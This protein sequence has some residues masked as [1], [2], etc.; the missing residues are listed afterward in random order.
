[1]GK[2]RTP[3]RGSD[4]YTLIEL[5]ITVAIIG[6]L[7]A[8]A[9][10]V[11]S[12]YMNKSRAQEAIQFLGTIKLRQESYRSEFGEYCDVNNINPGTFASPVTGTDAVNWGSPGGGWQQLG[13][14]PDGPVRFSFETRAGP[15]GGSLPSTNSWVNTVGSGW[16]NWGIDTADFWYVAEA[17]GDLNSD[18]TLVVFGTAAGMK[19]IWCSQDKGWD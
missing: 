18:G 19:N 17:A 5:M 11:F 4:A 15:P 14:H 16:G 13:A 6:I 8:I 9:I 10:P 3:G 1:M 7:S 12:S 2:N